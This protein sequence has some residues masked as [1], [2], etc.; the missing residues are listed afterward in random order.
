M[1]A[2]IP[3][4]F[5]PSPPPCK[6]P[7]ALCSPSI[8]F[9]RVWFNWSGWDPGTWTPASTPGTKALSLN[10]LSE[11]MFLLTYKWRKHFPEFR[12]LC[13]PAEFVSWLIHVLEQFI[14]NCSD[15]SHLVLTHG[16]LLLTVQQRH[17]FPDVETFLYSFS[18]VMKEDIL[19]RCL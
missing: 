16:F 2:P 8:P 18:S 9:P 7:H 12:S 15:K 19:A 3:P 14:Q 13:L 17:R 5:H 6:A 11:M 1:P 4:C 10:Y